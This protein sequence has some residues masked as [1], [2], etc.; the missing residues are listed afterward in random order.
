MAERYY[1][2]NTGDDYL[3]RELQR[4]GAIPGPDDVIIRSFGKHGSEDAHHYAR[5]AN[6]VQRKLDAL[7]GQWVNHAV[8]PT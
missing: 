5:T 8:L 2:Q 1:V 7:N 6:E 3:V 4:P